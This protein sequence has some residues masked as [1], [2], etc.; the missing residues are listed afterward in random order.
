MSV[1]SVHLFEV[2]HCLHPLELTWP[3]KGW[4]RHKYPSVAVL[5]QHEEL[6]TVL[7]D[8][9][10]ASH[11]FSATRYWPEKAYA[12]LTPV[13]VPPEQ[14]LLTQL[15][16]FGVRQH[17][18]SMIIMSH[19]HADHIAGLHDF[20]KAKFVYLEEGYQNLSKLSRVMQIK[21]G[22]L[23]SLLPGDFLMK[24]KSVSLTQFHRSEAFFSGR[25]QFLDLT[26]DGSMKLVHLPGHAEGHLGLYVKSEK[27]E[28]FFLADT[29]WHLPALKEKQ[30]PSFATKFIFSNSKQY[31]E[32]FLLASDLVLERPDIH[33]IP[34]HC[35]H[36]I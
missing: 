27:K 18:I 13:T 31:Q 3:G 10:Y 8:T 4:H 15:A 36:R 5:L 29:C 23:K 7:F 21:Q 14:D 35:T 25:V 2:G 11:F 28:Y 34:C 32:T 1:T 17:E 6:G 16:K 30:L 33:W 22:F 20:T 19:F 12:M 9:G 24:S 26:R